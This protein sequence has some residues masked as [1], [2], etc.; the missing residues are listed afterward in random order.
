MGRGQA[1]FGISAMEASSMDPQQRL[2]LEVGYTALWSAGY[3][4]KD[5]V[6]RN[7]GIFVGIGSNDWS[8]LVTQATAYTGTGAAA[9]IAANR[10]SYVFGLKGPSMSIDTACS[11]SLVS[12]D[13]ACLRLR[14][15]KCESAIVF[16]INL[17]LSPASLIALCRARMLCADARCKTFDASANGY[18]RGEG[19]GA[20]VLK[21][22][23]DATAAGDRVLAVVRGSGVNQDGRSAS[24]T[25]PN[26]PSQEEVILT[27]LQEAQV[28]PLDVEYV[29]THGTGTALGDPIEVGALKA[30]Q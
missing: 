8:S 4:R 27:A 24:L 23:S 25:A 3:D 15:N 12:L 30:A 6:S 5:L 26:G 18:V 28:S 16:G 1:F 19:C 21:R 22:L 14:I 9:S 13:A 17:L 7:V 20:V 2:L 11:S 29:E 10:L